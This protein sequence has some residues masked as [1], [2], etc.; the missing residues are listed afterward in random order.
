LSGLCACGLERFFEKLELF[1]APYDPPAD[2]AMKLK[3]LRPSGLPCVIGKNLL[4]PA[5]AMM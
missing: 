2:V 3:A 5:P 1:L 4:Q